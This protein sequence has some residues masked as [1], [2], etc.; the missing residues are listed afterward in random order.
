MDLEYFVA[1][2]LHVL[3]CNCSSLSCQAVFPSLHRAFGGEGAR[4]ETPMFVQLITLLSKWDS[5]LTVQR[6]SALKESVDG[7]E[8]IVFKDVKDHAVLKE[9]VTAPE[10]AAATAPE[11]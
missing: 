9:L 2:C 1:L 5:S 4:L 6:C 3:Q 10:A 7:S 11:S 8:S